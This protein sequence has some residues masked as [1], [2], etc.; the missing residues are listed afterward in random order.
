LPSPLTNA[1]A[2][3]NLICAGDILILNAYGTATS[4]TW[5][6]ANAEGMIGSTQTLSLTPTVTDNYSVAVS[7]GTC[8]AVGVID[9]TVNTC[10][11]IYGI[12]NESGFSIY[13]NPTNGLVFINTTSLLI[14][15]SI[16][17]Y[18]ISGRVILSHFMEELNDQ[19]NLSD[20][21]NGIYF[22]KIK[23]DGN[24]YNSSKN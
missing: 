8:T 24:N 4:Y 1:T 9:V 5:S 11:G 18:D 12:E 23:Q 20:L 17:I 16:E 6:S 7:D 15:T 19:I 14:N 2:S 22:I 10:T 21:S 13:P 3:S